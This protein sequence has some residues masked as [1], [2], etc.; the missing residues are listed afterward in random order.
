MAD[1]IHLVSVIIPVYNGVSF[2]A[3]AIE[4]VLAQNYQPLEII[5]VDDGSTDATAQVAAS[6]SKEV[7]YV[8]QTNAGPSAARNLGIKLAQGDM[9]AFLDVD[10]L[11][12]DHKLN[13]QTRYLMSNP[14]VEIVQGLIQTM[15]LHGS[16]SSKKHQ[17]K[18]TSEPYRYINIGSAL[19]R[20]HVFDKVG[21][22]DEALTDNEDT[23][24]FI[25]AWEKGVSKAVLDEVTL[26]YRKHN[27][28]LSHDQNPVN[29]GLTKLIKKHLDRGRSDPD[30]RLKSN[31]GYSGV[32]EYL[33]R[34]PEEM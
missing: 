26:F 19:Y 4:N 5:I 21:L 6:Y 22:F 32:V 13:L 2:L 16:V 3:G 10:D 29:Y 30:F 27:S 34:P 33:G 18:V 9:L 31:A 24:W 1:N 12:S 23:D 11:W 25:R 17:F 14:T 28:N 20:S 7:Q 8:R 15:Q